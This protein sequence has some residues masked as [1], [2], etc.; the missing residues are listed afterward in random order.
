MPTY[1]QKLI[2]RHSK[3]KKWLKSQA[4]KTAGAMAILFVPISVFA[5]PD[6]VPLSAALPLAA[7]GIVAAYRLRLEAAKVYGPDLGQ[8]PGRARKANLNDLKK[9]GLV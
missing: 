2:S 1:D 9:A 8:A 6:R 3:A 5:F 4:F 7:I